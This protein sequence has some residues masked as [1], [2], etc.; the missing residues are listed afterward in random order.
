MPAYVKLTFAAFVHSS[1]SEIIGMLQS[2]YAADGF[3]SQYTRQTKVWEQLIPAVQYSLLNFLAI[4]PAA[5]AWEV[6]LEYP[7]YRLRRRIDMVLTRC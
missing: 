3:L 6:L 1:A 5:S 4:R 7:L 2:S